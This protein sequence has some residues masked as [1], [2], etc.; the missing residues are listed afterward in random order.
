MLQAHEHCKSLLRKHPIDSDANFQVEVEAH[1][2]LTVIQSM[3][4][5]L[6]V[7]PQDYYSERNFHERA[8]KIGTREG[9]DTRG[10]RL[11]T[12]SAYEPGLTFSNQG[13]LSSDYQK[14]SPWVSLHQSLSYRNA[15]DEFRGGEHLLSTF[16]PSELWA[17]PTQ[18][19][20]LKH[21]K[22]LASAFST[23]HSF[24]EIPILEIYASNSLQASSPIW[25]SETSL[26]ITHKR[27][28]E[29]A[30]RRGK[31]PSP[32]ARAFSRGALRLPK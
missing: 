13:G 23:F 28:G 12:S 21:E 32:L 20:K 25:A 5:R 1:K 22:M 2:K 26:A 29:S 31:R 4:S 11:T 15:L 8:W 24:A 3:G 14:G 27:A 7:A 18:P 6:W 9:G 30:R 16:W 17:L 19:W 10:N